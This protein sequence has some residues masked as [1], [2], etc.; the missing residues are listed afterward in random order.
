MY[1][2]NHD[3]YADYS[4]LWVARANCMIQQVALDL[5]RSDMCPGQYDPSIYSQL[6]IYFVPCFDLRLL[7]HD[8]YFMHFNLHLFLHLT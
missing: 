2:I 4:N 7:N 3:I 5:Q 8:Y 1:Y 6:Y